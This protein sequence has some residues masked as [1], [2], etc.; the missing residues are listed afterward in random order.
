MKRILKQA[1]F[2]G[3]AVGVLLAPSTFMTLKGSQLHASLLRSYIGPKVV[4]ITNLNGQS[5]GT[6]FFVEA[7]SGNRYILTNSHV[8]LM[9]SLLYVE[10]QQVTPI[11]ISLS[12]PDLCL[13]APPKNSSARGALKV[14]KAPLFLGEFVSVLGHPQ[15]APLTLTS[16]EFSATVKVAV[17]FA[18]VAD[19]TQCPQSTSSMFIGFGFVCM[20]EFSAA[21]TTIVIEP[22][23]SGSPMFDAYGNVVGVVFAGDE[24]GR[25]FAVTLSDVQE[26]LRGR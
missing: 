3:A 4:R 11:E 22:G 25:A 7:P 16:G 19:P 24:L 5:G 18:M 2:V 15:L 20:R 17:A 13:L 14:R 9:P 1:L 8:C 6:G 12:G 21:Q 23:N 10:G 26:F